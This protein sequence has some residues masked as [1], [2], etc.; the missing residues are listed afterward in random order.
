[1][2]IYLKKYFLDPQIENNVSKTVLRKIKRIRR[3]MEVIIRR[4]AKKEKIKIGEKTRRIK[5]S[6][7]KGKK[8]QAKRDPVK[9]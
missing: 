1:M 5:G 4:T 9:P 7:L 6:R 3:K 2:A 8:L